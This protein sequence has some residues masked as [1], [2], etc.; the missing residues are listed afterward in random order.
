MN[1]EARG[2]RVELRRAY[3][4]DCERETWSDGRT[5]GSRMGEAALGAL[6]AVRT[7]C[8]GE[9]PECPWRAWS[10]PEVAAVIDAWA[11]YDKGQL[12]T[13]IGDDPPHW[14]VEGV[15]VF[16][17]ALESGRADVSEMERKAR[18]VARGR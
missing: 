11:A 17:R 10:D 16:S 18:E 5:V 15:L 8:G 9:P 1:A 13:V 3:R 7:V 2:A 4:C 12:A 6:A 14:L